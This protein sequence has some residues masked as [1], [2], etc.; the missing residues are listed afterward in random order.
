MYA[1]IFRAKIKQTNDEYFQL[2]QK[3]RE[4]AFSQYNCID[5]VSSCENN[6]EIAISHWQSL[7][8]IKNWKNNPQHLKAQQQAN[9]WYESYKTE[10][11]KIL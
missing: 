7:E 5:F 9:K 3:L 6:L 10:I 2:A 11:V 8:D 1:V 4:L